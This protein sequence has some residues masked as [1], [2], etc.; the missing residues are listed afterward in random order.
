MIIPPEEKRKLAS[1]L[2]KTS[3]SCVIYFTFCLVF[4][5]FKII[6]GIFAIFYVRKEKYIL[7]GIIISII[8]SEILGIFYN[9]IMALFFK[10]QSNKLIINIE[11]E[12]LLQE[13]N[14]F[15]I[16]INTF[17]RKHEYVYYLKLFN[18]M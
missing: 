18:E 16:M 13:W 12:H 14:Y 11:Y 10:K 3:I 1:Y 2:K 6:Y 8:F 7:T 17:K 4:N 9:T 15:D 5:I